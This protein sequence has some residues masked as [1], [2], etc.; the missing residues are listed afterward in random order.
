MCKKYT[1]T[2]LL[3]AAIIELKKSGK[4]ECCHILYTRIFMYSS[5]FINKYLNSSQPKWK[6]KIPIVVWSEI[7]TLQTKFLMLASLYHYVLSLYEMLLKLKS[8]KVQHRSIICKIRKI[9]SSERCFWN[10]Y[11]L[12]IIFMYIK[13]LI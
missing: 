10:W 7:T 5:N 1:S 11:Y 2:K 8:L 9:Y 6:I 3:I 12:Q 13:S 4:N